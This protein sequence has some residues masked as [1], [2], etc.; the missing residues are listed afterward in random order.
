VAYR[1]AV[2][3]GL[4][5]MDINL[6]T[7]KGGTVEELRDKKVENIQGDRGH[8]SMMVLNPSIEVFVSHR[9]SLSL[10]AYYFLRRSYYKDYDH[11]WTRVT[12]TQLSFAYHL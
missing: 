6:Y 5:V 12:D 1:H 11:V 10:E 7:W 8:A 4:D 3:I 2:D 9:L